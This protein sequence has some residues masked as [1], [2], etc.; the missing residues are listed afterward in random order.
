MMKHITLLLS[1]C[2]IPVLISAQNFEDF[3][4]QVNDTYSSFEEDTRKAFSDY[5]EKI[6]KDFEEYLKDNFAVYEI[7]EGLS[8]TSAPKPNEI[9]LKMKWPGIIF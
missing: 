7:S 5:V 4:K 8:A 2:L 6:D 9:P 1:Y 3:K